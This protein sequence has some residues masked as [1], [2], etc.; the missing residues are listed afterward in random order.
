M[1]QPILP[2]HSVPRRNLAR[3]VVSS[4]RAA[5]IR[6]EFS[7]G[8]PLAEPVLAE[9][10]GVSRAP[11]REA[12]IELEREGLVQ[13]EKTGR[14]RV[15]PL[16]GKDLVEIV[17]TRMALEA[18]GVRRAVEQWTGEDSA[19]IE[20][21]IEA[22]AKAET[23]A[24]LSQLDVEMHE[25]IM[26][27]AS[28]ERLLSL[29]QCI[30]PQFEMWLAHTHRLQGKLKVG[31][32]RVTVEGHRKLLSVIEAGNPD[33]AAEAMSSH[34]QT[35]YDWLPSV[36]PVKG[37]ASVAGLVLFALLLAMSY[38]VKPRGQGGMIISELMPH[39][40]S[41][42]DDLCLL[43][44]MNADNPLP[45]GATLQFHT[46]T[47]VD[48]RPSMGARGSYGLG[49]ENANLP[50]F[51]SIQGGGVLEYGSA[52]LPAIHQGTKLTCRHLGRDFRLTDVYG[53]VVTE[54]LG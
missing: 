30:R 25:Y 12:L 35:W 10:F 51:V 19:R 29:W 6:G 49:T 46:G 8:D 23:L 16:T 21:I 54:I 38:S 17:D 47:F 43:R 28:N 26:R 37:I 36:F 24:E 48:V 2:N 14:T 39:V 34:L 5:I 41:V 20:A 27:R 7:P 4:L 18:M 42:A 1:T 33:K 22:Q 40:A 31:P 9:R 11:V 53:G 52:C 50:S 15:R 45:V 13:F 3:E 32:R 44:G